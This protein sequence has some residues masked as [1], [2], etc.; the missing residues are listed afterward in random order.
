MPK[1]DHGKDKVHQL[2]DALFN[3]LFYDAK[4]AI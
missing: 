3:I 1:V 2:A 4:L